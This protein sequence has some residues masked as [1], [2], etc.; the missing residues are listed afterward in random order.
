MNCEISLRC[1]VVDGI[2]AT[3]LVGLQQSL[4]RQRC[5]DAQARHAAERAEQTPD[6]DGRLGFSRSS[7][8]RPQPT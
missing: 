2:L 8:T 7:P 1:V 5:K 3:S 6:D 4:L